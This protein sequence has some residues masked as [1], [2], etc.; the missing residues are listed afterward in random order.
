MQ[1]NFNDDIVGTGS[2]Q[3]YSKMNEHTIRLFG[4]GTNY[5]TWPADLIAELIGIGG[6]YVTFFLV[7]KEWCMLTILQ[8]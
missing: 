4:A 5:L 3:P 2:N 1:A 8:E 6:E 7:F